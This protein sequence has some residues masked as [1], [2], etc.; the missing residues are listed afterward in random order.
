MNTR[1][2]FE[3][4][5]SAW[6]AADEYPADSLAAITYRQVATDYATVATVDPENDWE[7]DK[8]DALHAD[9]KVLGALLCT[10]RLA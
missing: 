5:T 2:L 8:I 4:A 6:R 9:A 10:G 3:L 7:A 1:A